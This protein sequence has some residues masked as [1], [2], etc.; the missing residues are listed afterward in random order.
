MHI[1]M[2]VKYV[3]GS[4]AGAVASVVDQV[5]FEREH[6]KSIASLSTD[7]RLSDICWLAW[8]A[9]NRTGKTTEVFEVWLERVDEVEIG[10]SEIVPLETVPHT[11]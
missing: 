3:D 10:Q 8:H 1:G 5:A 7:F 6:D 4:A 9:L 2:N 11:G